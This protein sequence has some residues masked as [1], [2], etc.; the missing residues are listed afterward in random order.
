[1]KISKHIYWII[2]LLFWACSD[3]EVLETKADPV[4]ANLDGTAF[5][6]QIVPF[7]EEG[8]T[9]QQTR[10]S[11]SGDLFEDGDLMRL[12][13]IC[14]YVKSAE[15]GE[16]TW[17]S[18]EDNWRLF[19]YKRETGGDSGL[20]NDNVKVGQWTSIPTNKFDID[21]D[22][23]TSGAPNNYTS[24]QATPYVF[25]A[26]TWTEEIHVRI[27]SSNYLT[28]SNIFKADQRKAKDYK[29]SNVLWAQQYMQT[30]PVHVRLSFEHKM[31]ALRIDV[32]E[33]ASQ[34][35]TGSEEVILTLENMPD[36]DQQEVYIGNYFTNAMK[37]LNK[38]LNKFGDYYRCNCTIE[39][40]GR[41]LGIVYADDTNSANGYL[42]RKK[43]AELP[44]N[45]TYTAYKYSPT[46][47]WLIIPPYTVPAGVTPTLWLRKG[48]YRWSAPLTL[49]AGRTF[50]QGVRY[51]IKMNV[52]EPAPDPQP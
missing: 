30:G 1:M 20:P 28:Y 44:Q 5:E 16:N 36:I 9:A 48:E 24:P 35:P 42:S 25:T 33:L 47:F 50:R 43:F 51:N 2:P 3:N 11:L 32:S 34:L 39:E 17:G 41:A 8:E 14:P 22:F 31:A 7:V 4:W 45:A 6:T 18:S 26:T 46:D 29:A 27:G 13:I 21:G 52:P 23:N 19:Q 40:N 37:E 15:Y 38:N 12:R 49:P 10:V